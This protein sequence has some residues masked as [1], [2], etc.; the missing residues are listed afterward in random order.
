M[1]KYGYKTFDKWFDESY[2]LEPDDD[3]RMEMCVAEIER[4]CKFDDEWCTMYKEMIPT[5]QHNFDV[6]ARNKHLIVSN[7]NFVET[8]EQ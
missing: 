3:K 8:R 6:L 5:L 2:D 4:L 1:K 7:L